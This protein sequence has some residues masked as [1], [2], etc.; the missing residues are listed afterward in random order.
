[1][2]RP[3]S[4]TG[5]TVWQDAASMLHALADEHASVHFIRVAII[6]DH[7]VIIIIII[8]LHHV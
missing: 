4:W 5:R 6:M 7:H 1:M 2:T 8:I 3:A